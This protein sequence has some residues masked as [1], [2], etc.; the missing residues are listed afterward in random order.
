MRESIQSRLDEL[1]FH[2]AGSYE[3]K[4][5]VSWKVEA[6]IQAR[7]IEL[8]KGELAIFKP[9]EI[10]PRYNLE[11]WTEE[12]AARL[13]ANYG[14]VA[15]V[16]EEIMEA[17]LENLI[18]ERYGYNEMEVLMKERARKA[19]AMCDMTPLKMGMNIICADGSRHSISAEDLEERSRDV[20]LWDFVEKEIAKKQTENHNEQ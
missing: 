19:I 1:L 2:Q 5:A 3:L 9:D 20:G 7:N 6:A 8:L 10:D 12:E 17:N 18:V 13:M 16:E 11:T 14:I 4:Q 15:F